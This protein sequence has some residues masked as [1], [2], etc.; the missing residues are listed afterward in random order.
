VNS[1]FGFTV[2]FEALLGTLRSQRSGL[3]ERLDPRGRKLSAL[4]GRD[5]SAPGNARGIVQGKI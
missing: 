4:E 1:L 3:K 2:W 5:M